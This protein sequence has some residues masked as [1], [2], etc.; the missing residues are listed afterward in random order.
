MSRYVL[1]CKDN[2][3]LDTKFH[4]LNVS[5]QWIL[6]DKITFNVYLSRM[7]V[8]IS[9]ARGEN[10]PTDMFDKIHF[11]I[12]WIISLW[13]TFLY[14]YYMYVDTQALTGAKY[15]ILDKLM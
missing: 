8:Y 10:P 12:F 2:Q 11:C 15:L 7:C 14:I 1:L 6:W 3:I 5:I 4:N 13:R 9:T